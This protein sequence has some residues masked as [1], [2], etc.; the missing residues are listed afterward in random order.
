MTLEQAG[1]NNLVQNVL[2]PQ[3]G[4]PMGHGCEA[5]TATPVQKKNSVEFKDMYAQNDGCQRWR[6][7]EMAESQMMPSSQGRFAT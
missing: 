5:S 7:C 2:D 6:C 3:C 4:V 1:C